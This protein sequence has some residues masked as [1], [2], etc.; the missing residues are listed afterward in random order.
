MR[1]ISFPKKV[2]GEDVAQ[3]P[4]AFLILM[5]KEEQNYLESRDRLNKEE[6]VGMEW[7]SIALVRDRVRGLAEL[8]R[9]SVR[10]KAREKAPLK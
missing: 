10:G 6:K 9:I 3:G 8:R 1:R 7:L 5:P 4:A 2:A